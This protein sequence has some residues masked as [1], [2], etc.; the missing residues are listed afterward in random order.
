MKYFIGQE[1]EHTQAHNKLTLFVVGLQDIDKILKQAKKHGV[2]HIYLG[3]NQS[4]DGNSKYAELVDGCI[5]G[6]YLTS[7][8]I[9]VKY[10][11]AIRKQ[12]PLFI[13]IISVQVPNIESLGPNASIKID[14]DITNKTNPG[15]WT[16]R[17]NALMNITVFTG[18][19]KYDN[20][21]EVT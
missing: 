18:W 11:G 1:V 14:D 4:F 5:A 12:H 2:E 20:D 13:P 21:K 9:D 16:H 7:L 3:A 15:V 10:V 8:D 17:V 19:D 6:G